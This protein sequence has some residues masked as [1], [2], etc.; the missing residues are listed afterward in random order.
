MKEQWLPGTARS[1]T[2]QTIDTSRTQEPS[3]F[4][5]D[6]RGGATEGPSA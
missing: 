5:P 4:K 3:D 6:G 2:Y 1:A